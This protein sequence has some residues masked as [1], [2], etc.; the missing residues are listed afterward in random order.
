[1]G[2]G[3]VGSYYGALLARDGHAVT[4]V[5]RGPHL[6]ALRSRGAVVVREADGRRWEAP[7]TALARPG[8]GP[9]DLAVVT[10]KSHHTLT[11]AEALRG[12]M[13]DGT[14]VLSLQNGMENMGRLASVVGVE[15]VL[16][17]IAFVGLRV[18]EPGVVRHEA[19]GWVRLGHPTDPRR[20]AAAHEIVAGSWEVSP[21]RDIVRDQWHKLLWNAG[22]NAIC[23]VTGAT[24]GE[25]LATPES[26]RLVREA[27]YEVVAVAAAHGVTLTD[28]DVDEM[29]APDPELRHYRP[30]TARDLDAGKR[31]ERD[32]LCGFLAREGARLGVPTP[33]NAVLD[34]LLALQ[35][36]R[37]ARR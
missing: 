5:A 31:L 2:A 7:V 12:A 6:D 10:T 26:E 28:A 4:M 34:A 20:T 23:A 21:S 19:Q 35:E 1:M 3:A 15:R 13:A 25:A 9:Y 36:G 32:A 11:A 24:A 18:E 16:G 27:M 33:V 14:L 30:S 17:G 8:A 37:T 29:A 22:F